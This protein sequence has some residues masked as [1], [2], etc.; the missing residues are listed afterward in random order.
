MCVCLN[1]LWEISIKGQ[2]V[3]EREISMLP[4]GVEVP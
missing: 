1:V 4:L 2:D 3:C